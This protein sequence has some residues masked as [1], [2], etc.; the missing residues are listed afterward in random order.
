[1]YVFFRGMR[2]GDFSG[3][4]GCEMHVLRKLGFS[5]QFEATRQT[6]FHPLG[7][8]QKSCSSIYRSKGC[9]FWTYFGR[10][11]GGICL[12]INRRGGG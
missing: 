12:E 1:V 4:S 11:G 3:W 10:G 9:T 2:Q 6:G 7:A 8:S 5:C